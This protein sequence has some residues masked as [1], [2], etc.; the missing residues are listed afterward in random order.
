MDPTPEHPCGRKLTVVE[1]SGPVQLNSNVDPPPTLS[2]RLV[3]CEPTLSGCPG[4]SPIPAGQEINIKV[5]GM[6]ATSYAVLVG[7]EPR[8]KDN[9]W[10]Y[11]LDSFN[12]GLKIFTSDSGDFT[13]PA[14]AWQRLKQVGR[15]GPVGFLYWSAWSCSPDP[16]DPKAPPSCIITSDPQM[17]LIVNHTPAPMMT[18]FGRSVRFLSLST[19][20][21][22]LLGRE[23]GRLN[24]RWLLKLAVPRPGA[25]FWRHL[26]RA[27]A[28]GCVASRDSSARNGWRRR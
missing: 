22:A 12:N 24:S 11:D 1:A 27:P 19:S 17:I 21:G 10:P 6:W 26:A 5:L 2:I 7:S 9:A 13:M 25:R 8:T 16:N 15:P 14:D 3:C 4:R 23:K 20:H 28:R 18:D